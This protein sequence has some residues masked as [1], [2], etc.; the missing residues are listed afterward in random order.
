MV[1]DSKVF[2]YKSMIINILICIYIFF[3]LFPIGT[4]FAIFILILL[5]TPIYG[6]AI[7]FIKK[8]RLTEDYLESSSIYGLGKKDIV[9][10]KDITAIRMHDKSHGRISYYQL[11]VHKPRGG[12]LKINLY[13]YYWFERKSLIKALGKHIEIPKYPPMPKLWDM[14]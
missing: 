13:G 9:E 1:G 12:I 8:I 5:F 2:G 14:M 10:W 6:W 7:P 11:Y 4:G 3:F